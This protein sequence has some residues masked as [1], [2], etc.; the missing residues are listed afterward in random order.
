MGGVLSGEAS[1]SHPLSMGEET[2]SC[3][4]GCG[5]MLLLVGVAL[6]GD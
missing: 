4:S 5:H 6:S 1:C 2:H 3:F